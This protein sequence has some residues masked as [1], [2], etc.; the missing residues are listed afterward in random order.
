MGVSQQLRNQRSKLIFCSLP[1]ILLLSCSESHTSMNVRM[2]CGSKFY[3]ITS[4]CMSSHFEA[5][6]PLQPLNDYLTSIEFIASDSVKNQFGLR[7]YYMRRFDYEKG[8]REILIIVD[9]S[10]GKI[11][12]VS[13]A[14]WLSGGWLPNKE[15]GTSPLQECVDR[16]TACEEFIDG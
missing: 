2:P 12:D 13:V 11:S 1:A 6:Q 10:N 5:G 9:S 8:P 7:Q 4:V 15:R 16:K 3:Q 14:K